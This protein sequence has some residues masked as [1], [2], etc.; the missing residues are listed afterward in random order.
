MSASVISSNKRFLISDLLIF[1][2]RPIRHCG[3]MLFISSLGD[4]MTGAV[5]SDNGVRP[6]PIS[7]G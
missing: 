1:H 4:D 3:D 2:R 5:A 6:G 7:R